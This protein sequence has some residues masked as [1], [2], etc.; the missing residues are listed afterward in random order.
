MPETMGREKD[1]Q[2]DTYIRYLTSNDGF[3]EL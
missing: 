2:V 1:R 3:V